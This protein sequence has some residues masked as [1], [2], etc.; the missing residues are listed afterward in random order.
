MHEAII[1]QDLFHAVCM[2]FIVSLLAPIIDMLMDVLGAI[3][4]ELLYKTESIHENL[5]KT[6]H[7]RPNRK[8]DKS[9]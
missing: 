3:Q 9:D 6:G 1:V 5:E 2:G 4:E 7:M 8:G